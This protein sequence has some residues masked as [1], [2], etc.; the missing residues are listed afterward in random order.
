[1]ATTLSTLICKSSTLPVNLSS[2]MSESGP[3]PSDVGGARSNASVSPLIWFSSM[4]TWISIF[5]RFSDEGP[6]FCCCCCCRA[7]TLRFK[8]S[9]FPLNSRSL[10]SMEQTLSLSGP[11]PFTVGGVRPSTSVIPVIWFS[12]MAI[13]TVSP[14]AWF[15]VASTVA[16]GTSADTG[17]RVGDVPAGA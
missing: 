1:M 6:L 13:C 5:F 9:T 15:S 17:D 4:D 11:R 7:S 8:S 2:L 16:T 10:F 3:C 12:S 14:L